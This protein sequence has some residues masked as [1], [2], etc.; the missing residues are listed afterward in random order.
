MKYLIK[1]EKFGDCNFLIPLDKIIS[2]RHGTYSDFEQ[3]NY[4]NVLGRAIAI[5][6]KA[7]NDGKLYKNP[8]FKETGYPS[9]LKREELKTLAPLGKALSI[10]YGSNTA[11]VIKNINR[12]KNLP[13][14]GLNSLAYNFHYV[15]WQHMDD[16]SSKNLYRDSYLFETDDRS[17]FTSS[18]VLPPSVRS[19]IEING[20]LK[21]VDQ[22]T[23]SEVIQLALFSDFY[24]N[25]VDENKDSVTM[26]NT[27]F[28]DKNTHFL[29][30]YTLDQ[31]VP[32]TGYT[33]RQ[34]LQ[35]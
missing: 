24:R 13:L 18:I 14:F 2:L 31:K 28:A 27:T 17:G 22:L 33:L 35:A 29:I 30:N 20:K 5:V 8:Y 23:V 7:S 12:K 9:E 32:G 15:M 11:N 19:E 16:T 3:P 26:Q 6:V 1:P 21:S 4:N 34:M 10:I 25:V